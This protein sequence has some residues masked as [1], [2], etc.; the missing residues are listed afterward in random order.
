[1]N[2][3]SIIIPHAPY[4]DSIVEQAIA[5]ASS[6][7]LRCDVIPVS[8]KEG[9]GTGWAR[10]EG[11]AL[12]DSLF[13]V[14]LDADDTLR[15]DAIERMVA[16]YAYNHYVYC[17]SIEGDSIHVTP[18]CGVYLNETWHTVSALIPTAAF[19]AVGG[20]NEQLPALED[21]EFFMRLQAFGVCGV[22]CPHPLLR[23]TAGGRRSREFKQHPAY[24]A[25]HADIFNKWTGAIQMGCGCGAAVSG[26]IPENKL[27]TDILVT[28]LYSKRQ[29]VGP[30]TGRLYNAP[31][32]SESYQL[33]VDPRDQEA[34]P[35]MWQP[36]KVIDH[37][38]TPSVD[39]VMAMYQEA[40]QS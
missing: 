10:N 24:S 2:L 26:Q 25:T 29:T 11:V 33:W 32:G 12:S 1:M 18:D 22:R 5:A 17:D 39:D 40:V 7:S 30:V 37:N 15:E 16:S 28:A 4:H 13:I 8:D 35:D 21:T 6:Q 23:Y 19:K 27:D 31:R 36:V 20:F 14:C 38:I 34:K 3:V 9:R